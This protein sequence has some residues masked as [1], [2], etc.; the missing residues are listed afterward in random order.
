[1]RF[2]MLVGQALLPVYVAVAVLAGAVTGVVAEMEDGVVESVG[3]VL[4]VAWTGAAAFSAGAGV[5]GLRR[6]SRWA[7]AHL[8][9][10]VMGT[11]IC[12][13]CAGFGFGAL[14]T[15]VVWVP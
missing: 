12:A 10:V 9:L 2:E 5:V 3:P 11:Q 7:A 15:G 14:L 1:M 4:M 6:P 13:V 8:P